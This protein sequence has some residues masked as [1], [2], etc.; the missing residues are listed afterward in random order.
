MSYAQPQVHMGSA[1][2]EPEH[3]AVVWRVGHYLR[4]D[5]PHTFRCDIQLKQGQRSI[6]RYIFEKISVSA[7]STSFMYWFY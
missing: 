4:S 3:A 2:Y 5:S 1:K 6:T 7:G